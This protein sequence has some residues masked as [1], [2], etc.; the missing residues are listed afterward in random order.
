MKRRINL[1]RVHFENAEEYIRALNVL[2]HVGVQV[3]EGMRL[4]APYAAGTCAAHLMEAHLMAGTVSIGLPP[5]ICAAMVTSGVRLYSVAELERLAACSFRK[6]PRFPVFHVP[7]DGSAF[8]TELMS[9]VCVPEAEFMAYH[10]D[11]RDRDTADMIPRPYFGGGMTVRCEVSRLLCDVERL[12][13]PE[14][15]MEQYGMGFCYERAYDGRVV[16]RVT[17][18]V[19]AVARMY[20]DRHHRHINQFCRQ[21]KRVILFDMHSYHDE[22]LPPFARRTGPVTPDLCIGTDPR[23]TPPRLREIVRSR[24]TA[25]GFTTAENNPYSGLYIPECATQENSPCDFVGIMLEFHRRAYCNGQREAIRERIERI[26]SVIREIM[27]DCVD[28]S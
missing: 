14:E 20:Y 3:T 12:T 27:A 19:K 8:P 23:F 21:H 5:F 16:K 24:F 18:K 15:I 2:E 22:I 11:M 13:G 28:L 25:A 4:N 9:S 17:Q 7:H 6:V 26:R 1:L 10:E